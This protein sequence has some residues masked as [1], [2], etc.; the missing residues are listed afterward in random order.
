MT[1]IMLSYKIVQNKKLNKNNLLMKNK[2]YKI[3]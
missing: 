1:R 2:I 3:N